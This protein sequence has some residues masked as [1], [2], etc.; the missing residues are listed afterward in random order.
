MKERSALAM[1]VVA[2][3]AA[4]LGFWV[5]RLSSVAPAVQG[6]AIGSPSPSGGVT[7]ARAV[8]VALRHTGR[9]SALFA[10]LRPIGEIVEYPGDIRPDTLVWV[11]VL[12]G[13]FPPPSCGG[14]LTV[15]DEA[16]PCPPPNHSAVA[17]IDYTTGRW[18]MTGSP[19][20]VYPVFPAA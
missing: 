2:L 19:A 6:Q 4:A 11:V 18:L 5:G 12:E 15:G 16:K 7:K 10:I 1:V 9:T 8:Q 3:L 14:V 17:F 13:T 20:T